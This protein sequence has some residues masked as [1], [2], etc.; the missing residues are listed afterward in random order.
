MLAH[1]TF[2]FNVYITHRHVF[3]TTSSR[4]PSF[5]THLELL[6]KRHTLKAMIWQQEVLPKDLSQVRPY[7]PLQLLAKRHQPP[8]L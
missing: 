5:P 4:K 1:S 2:Q 3:N 7:F 6:P 8:V